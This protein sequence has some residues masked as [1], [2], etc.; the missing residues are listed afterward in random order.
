MITEN[1]A[2][3]ENRRYRCEGFLTKAR[4]CATLHWMRILHLVHQYPPDHVGGVEQYT[5][6]TATA[7]GERGHTVGVCYRQ[8]A[9]GAGWAERAAGAVQLY[10]VWDGVRTPAQRFARPSARA[11]SRKASPPCWTASSLTWCTSSIC[12]GCRWRCGRC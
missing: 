1:A 8:D 12:W 9:P 4:N 2:I 5:Q 11:G 7:L 3:G 10:P 6:A